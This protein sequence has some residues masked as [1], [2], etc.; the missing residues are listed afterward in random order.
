MFNYI[1]GGQQANLFSVLQGR[2]TT[3]F[4]PTVSCKHVL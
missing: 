3:C 1:T 4:Y 2:E